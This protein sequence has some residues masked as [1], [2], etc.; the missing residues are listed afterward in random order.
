MRR[1]Q[2]RHELAKSVRARFVVPDALK[3]AGVSDTVEIAENMR[4]RADEHPHLC[5]RRNAHKAVLTE[6]ETVLVKQ[7]DAKR[8]AVFLQQQHQIL[9]AFH[10][11]TC[12]LLCFFSPS[13][14][15][16][17]RAIFKRTVPGLPARIKKAGGIQHASDFPTFLLSWNA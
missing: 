15:P 16:P 1:E 12:F 17:Q 8:I 3:I 14:L 6:H 7:A 5:N 2:F 13:I 9:S 4:Q 11:A 10:T